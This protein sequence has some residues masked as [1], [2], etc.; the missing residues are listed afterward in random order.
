M[1]FELENR[2]F[3]NPGGETCFFEMNFI[4]IQGFSFF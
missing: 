1:K 4:G 2:P 3:E